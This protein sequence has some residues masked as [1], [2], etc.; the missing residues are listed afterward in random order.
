M[1][2]LSR[3]LLL[4]LVGFSTGT[5]AQPLF[6]THLH[7]NKSH[8]E[9]L[10]P[11]RIIEILD[12]NNISHALI[13][14]RPPELVLTLSLQARERII[15]FL[16]VYRHSEDKENWHHN[17]ELPVIVDQ[18]L[19]QGSWRGIG[20]LHIFAPD[21]HSPI[22]HSL[23]NLAAE[24][25]LPLLM[26]ADPAVIDTLYEWQP[27]LTVIWAHAGTYPYPDLL[28]DYLQRYPH[29]YIDLS[30]RDERHVS[31]GKIADGCYELFHRY[32]DRF[33]D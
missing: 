5:L 21:R 12:Q 6:D 30:V 27:D 20:E 8:T 31:N 29:L 4:S 13:T 18:Q 33:L 10:P 22:F 11:N 15:P 32:T 25:K 16:G 26:H 1:S 17:S 9:E 19:T 3:Y 2:R 14:S 7:Y 24:H 23:V 28:A